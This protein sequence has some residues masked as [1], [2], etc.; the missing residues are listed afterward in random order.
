MD[1]QLWAI[2]IK[3]NLLK[4]EQHSNLE[5]DTPWYVK[6]LLAFSGWLAA[7]FFLG[8]WAS[9]FSRLYKN[10]PVL[11]VIGLTLIVAAYYLLTRK[12]ANEFFEHLAFAISLAGQAL[13]VLAVINAA[14]IKNSIIIFTMLGFMQLALA[15]IMPH[16]IH[17]VFSSFFAA[18][19][20]AVAIYEA[21][22]G[23]SSLHI[24][25]TFIMLIA[26]LLWLN[27]FSFPKRFE[28]IQA[29]AYGF[30][31]ALITIKGTSLFIHTNVWH[32]PISQSSE[33]LKPWVGEVLLSTVTLYLVWK[34]LQRNKIAPLSKTSILALS[35][36][37]LLTLLSLQAQ[38]LILGA[39]IILLGF[40]SSN[41]VLLG[42]GVISLL[43]FI[44]N[45]YYWLDNSLLEKSLTL[46]LL[47]I[48]LIFGY[49]LIPRL[50]S[51]N[52]KGEIQ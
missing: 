23:S 3:E 37:L 28:L 44:S 19:S 4:G 51:D 1:K 32:T 29:N 20:F 9:L 17:R 25:S 14:D 46:L 7:S 52:S 38:G 16:F 43:F 36:T 26:I 8:F 11:I 35:G 27:E 15:M 6:V 18:L 34:L 2:L 30:I 45:Y 41:R 5:I 13:L 50:L 47:G 12:K 39:V 10:T 22:N 42:L 48:A 24:Y 49:W 33:W 21:S 40:S 31:F